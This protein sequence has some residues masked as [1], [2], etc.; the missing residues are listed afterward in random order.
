[1]VA[2]VKFPLPKSILDGIFLD[3]W[4][5]LTGKLGEQKEGYINIQMLF[6][7]RIVSFLF[8]FCDF[9]WIG[10]IKLNANLAFRRAEQP[11]IAESDEDK[12]SGAN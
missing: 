3:E 1:M 12:P 6:T 4:I 10:L 11:A 9:V 7:V 2:F 8:V 5:P